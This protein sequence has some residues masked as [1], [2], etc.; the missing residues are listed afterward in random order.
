MARDFD[1]S[2]N[3]IDRPK[4]QLAN[5]VVNGVSASLKRVESLRGKADG[6]AQGQLFE[7]ADQDKM[8]EREYRKLLT[9]S[10]KD[11]SLEAQARGHHLVPRLR[12]LATASAP[13]FIEPEV[14]SRMKT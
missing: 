9:H 8:A 2:K 7:L 12:R 1:F 5:E 13:P 3:D 10:D 6:L 14:S 4:A 11:I